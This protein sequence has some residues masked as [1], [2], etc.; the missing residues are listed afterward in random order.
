MLLCDSAFSRVTTAS[1]IMGSSKLKA[2]R[3][4]RETRALARKGAPAA[5]D[6]PTTHPRT[7]KKPKKDIALL[8]GDSDAAQVLMSFCNPTDTDKEKDRRTDDFVSREIKRYAE[9]AALKA[10]K[11]CMFFILYFS[12]F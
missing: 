1:T 10:S 5:S 8:D 9:A 2:A 6:E 12:L 11:N 4:N 3:Q 7:R